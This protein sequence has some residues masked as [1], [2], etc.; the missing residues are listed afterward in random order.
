ME[1]NEYLIRGGVPA[2]ERLSSAAF[3]RYVEIY[4]R[5]VHLTD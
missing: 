5:L 2:R 1:H 3:A 4:T